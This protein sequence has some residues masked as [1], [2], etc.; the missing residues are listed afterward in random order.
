MEKFWPF[1]GN[2]TCLMTNVFAEINRS[3]PT[4]PQ[5][6]KYILMFYLNASKILYAWKLK[7]T[8]FKLDISSFMIIN[9]K[10]YHH[11]HG[12]I[13]SIP[14]VCKIQYISTRKHPITQC[15][16]KMAFVF[17]FFACFKFISQVLIFFNQWI[18]FIDTF[19]LFVFAGKCCNYSL[20]HYYYHIIDLHKFAL[21]FQKL[22]TTT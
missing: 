16:C 15:D 13:I 20:V 2:T 5:F 7:Y 9:I 10:K 21:L 6:Y 19:I 8:K 3:P 1:L 12:N 11:F 22:V 4:P 14:E 17:S 18:S